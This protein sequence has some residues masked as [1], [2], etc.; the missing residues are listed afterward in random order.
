MIAIPLTKKMD[1]KNPPIVTIII[2]LM[3]IF[4]F[5]AIQ[6]DDEARQIEAAEFYFESGLGDIEI[7]QYFNYLKVVKPERYQKIDP[8]DLSADS[9]KRNMIGYQLN[10]DAGFLSIV[11][12]GE[13]EFKTADDRR[14]HRWLRRDF[15]AL[16]A[17]ILSFEYGFRPAKPRMET[18]LTTMFLHGGMGHL[19]GNMLFLWLIGC[20]IEYG[21]RR[22]LFVVIYGIGGFAATGFFWLLNMDS[23]IPLIGAS[24][25]IA[26]I[27]GAFT[28]L[29]GFKKVR[30]FLNLG[31]YFNYLKFPA[32]IMLPLWLGNEIFQMVTNEG[33]GIAY[34]AHLG[35]LL[36]GSTLALVLRPIPNLLDMEGFEDAQDDLVQ[37]KIEKALD[38]MGRLEFDDA[39]TLLM[40]AD[41]LQPEDEV[42]LKHLFAIDRLD[43]GKPRYHETSK[44][45][46][47]TLCNNPQT[48]AQ[49]HTIYREYI[50]AAR[51]AKL[52]GTIYL[53]L[54]RAFCEIGKLDDAQR[55]VS[56]LAKR[57]AG[58][59]EV[60]A[61]LLK[62]AGLY[63]KKVNNQARKACLVSIC[64]QYP[65]SAE[66]SI[67]KQQL[68]SL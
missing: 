8:G 62:L 28:V 50:K 49:A 2:I 22:W 63:A 11:E 13:L 17:R 43:P 48:Y 65:M 45:Y 27:M 34:A 46:L 33:S 36:G 5:F 21:C 20:M 67:A 64:R 47:N 4:V 66:A 16:Q 60:P 1:W 41:G 10:F 9:P 32:I 40:E 35:G 25:A 61:L 18:W 31:F 37:P 55:L 7:Q 51:P 6:G 39:R 56:V 44:K 14:R 59:E 42:I 30:I 68:A 23:L 29:Y 24:G 53:K 54:S 3:N 19:L 58:L 12:K 15:D 38:H 52:G 57:C 26:G